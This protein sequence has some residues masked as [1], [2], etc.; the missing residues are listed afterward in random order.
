MSTIPTDAHASAPKR[1]SRT[2]IA[3][4]LIL[5]GCCAFLLWSYQRIWEA[6]DPIRGLV[7]TLGSSADLETRIAAARDLGM[8]KNEELPIAIP[9]LVAALEDTQQSPRVRAGAARSLGNT[10]NHAVLADLA[11]AHLAEAALAKA[12][13]DTESEVQIESANSLHTMR[14]ST[15]DHYRF[16]FDAITKGLVRQLESPNE[17]VR[18]TSASL[19][20]NFGNVPGIRI[21]PTLILVFQ[22]DPSNLVRAA[23]ASSLSGF[24]IETDRAMALF[25][26]GLAENDPRVQQQCADSLSRLVPSDDALPSLLERI[27]SPDRLTRARCATLLGHLGSKSAAVFPALLTVLKEPAMKTEERPPTSRV[28][29]SHILELN[30]RGEAATAIGGLASTLDAGSLQA[31]VEGIRPLLDDRSVNLRARA[32]SAIGQLGTAAQELI[33]TL[34]ALQKDDPDAFIKIEAGKAAGALKAARD[35]K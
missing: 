7:K 2:G 32:I 3:S 17:D 21:P 1:R 13:D 22:K 11:G 18:R 26:E 14:Y 15:A 28:A 35:K 10:G 24:P 8:V 6:S 27:K 12:L 20:G 31:A 30:P 5:A 19:L 4:L 33:P 34:E 25:F 16:D 23:A 29:D 9:A